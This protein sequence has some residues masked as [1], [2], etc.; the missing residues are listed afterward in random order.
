MS[1]PFAS[2]WSLDPRI[3]FLNHG[4]FG[5]CPS[6]V[7]EAQAQIRARLEREPVAFMLRELPGLLDE[8][9]AALAALVGA[10]ADDLAFVNNATT[11]V[12]TVLRSLN[13]APG[14]ELLT[15][16]HGYNACRNAL[17]YVAERSGARVVVAAVPFPLTSRDEV[18]DAVMNRVTTRTR[19]ALLDHITSSTA[20]VFPIAELVERL[21][22]RGVD[23]LVDGA[24]AP[25]MVELELAQLG[26]AYYTANCHKWLCAPKGSAFLHVRRDRQ[27]GIRPLV[28][29]HGANA[30][31][32]GRSRFRHEFDWTGT[33]DPTPFLCV[34]DAIGFLEQ[35]LPGGLP[36]LMARNH[37]LA[38]EARAILCATLGIAP[39]A[40]DDMLGA[41]VTLPLP[42]GSQ[43][44]QDQLLLEDRI[45]VPIFPWPTNDSRCLRVT[46]QLY[47]T[48]E[49]YERLA[50]ALARRLRRG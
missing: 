36:E 2:L 24:H 43:P 25:G 9:R 50:Q 1:A 32:G 20:L 31:D 4:S 18:L 27:A 16:D 13:F 48:P 10:A 6:V 34:V 19:L 22:A 28:I 39:P 26:A 7:L 17:D 5:A 46:A 45:E 33:Q 47:N 40:P 35:L 29:S 30:Q 21:A 38:L 23:T 37:A 44:L 14:D 3:D 15:T 42:A 8:A 11:G 12:N 41:M 49:Q